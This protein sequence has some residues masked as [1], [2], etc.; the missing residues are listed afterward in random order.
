MVTNTPIYSSCWRVVRQVTFEGSSVPSFQ[1]CFH[2]CISE[3]ITCLLVEVRSVLFTALRLKKKN[4]ENPW[5]F[6][7]HFIPLVSFYTL[8]K[9][10]KTSGFLMF[11][12]GIGRDQW[13]EMGWKDWKQFFFIFSLL[14]WLYLVYNSLNES[15]EL[16]LYHILKKHRKHRSWKKDMEHA[17]YFRS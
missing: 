17:L 9:H 11:S 12:G 14:K 1:Y 4:H 10:Q 13:P 6:S 16:S 5:C 7:A 2:H 15:L 8:L 3:I